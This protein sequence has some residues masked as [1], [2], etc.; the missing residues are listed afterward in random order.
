MLRQRG[1]VGLMA[2]ALVT[3]VVGGAQAHVTTEESASIL[4]FPRVIA[5]G[6][7]DTIIQITNTSNSMVHA[8]CFYVNGALTDPLSPPCNPNDPFCTNPPLWTELDFDIWLTKQQP[9]HW[10][11]SQGRNPE[12]TLMAEPCDDNPPNFSCNDAGLNIGA[13][14]P[15]VEDFTG[16]LKCI[17]VDMTGAPVS[18]N[19]L[20]G[21]ATE[22][23][24][25]RCRIGDDPPSTDRSCVITGQD[26]TTSDDCDDVFDVAKY[27]AIGIIGNENNDGD[28][29][30]CLGGEPSEQ[31]P[32]G[33]EYNAC[34]AF[35][36]ANHFADGAEDPL[37]GS[38]SEVETTWT[39]VPCTQNF[40]SQTPETVT[41]FIETFNE[42]EQSFSSFAN[43]TCWGNFELN[44]PEGSGPVPFSV[45]T[46][47]SSFVQSRLRSTAQTPSGFLM[48]G[49]ESHET[50]D[51]YESFAAVNYHVEGERTGGDIIT[52]PADQVGQTP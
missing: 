33:A 15:E 51:E 47:G 23:I 11:V 41:I 45:D 13:V 31:C 52:I 14:P 25:N 39:I 4:V 27:N 30:L 38:G 6:T 18:G 2:A 17:E 7:R 44:H 24:F 49:L 26:C 34:P 48:V 8:H 12:A 3:L 16:E 32:N 20:K 22:V 35:W 29:V 50:E 1:R 36:I 10:V 28:P 40:E 43:F 9:T 5:D 42:F 21:E 46:L 37:V 19:H